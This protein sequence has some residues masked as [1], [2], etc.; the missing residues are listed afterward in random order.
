MIRIQENHPT[1]FIYPGNPSPGLG[2]K[3][4]IPVYNE[5]QCVRLVFNKFSSNSPKPLRAFLCL[6]V[7][8]RCPPYCLP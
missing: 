1:P 8:P 6:F 4:Q 3:N 7:V 2:K 5:G